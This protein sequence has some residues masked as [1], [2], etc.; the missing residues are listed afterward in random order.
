V[1]MDL[2]VMGAMKGKTMTAAGETMGEGPTAPHPFAPA[3]I[4]DSGATDVIEEAEKD[5]ETP[6]ESTED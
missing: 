3:Q 4:D 6:G 5:P 2:D 1:M